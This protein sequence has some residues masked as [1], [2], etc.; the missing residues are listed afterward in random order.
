MLVDLPA[1]EPD[2]MRRLAAIHATTARAKGRLYAGAGDVTEVVHLPILLARI[3]MQW[4]RRFG[5]T[6]VNLFVTDVPGP[7]APLWLA[8]ARMLEAVPVAPLVQHVGL[9]IAALSYAGELVVS[10]HADGS[11]T[12][13]QL[14]ADGLA[15]DLAAFRAAT[16]T[17]VPA[18]SHA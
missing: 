3:G 7:P 8:G 9:G 12:D 6:R 18:E 15:A 2:P 5:G 17:E 13:L 16:P 14:L 4:M 1:G 11:V 10:V